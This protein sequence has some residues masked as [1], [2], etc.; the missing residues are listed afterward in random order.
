MLHLE[1]FFNLFNSE[2]MFGT[3]IT[4]LAV[5]AS[6]LAQSDATSS[7]PRSYVVTHTKDDYS[8]TRGGFVEETATNRR[9]LTFTTEVANYTSTKTLTHTPDAEI[10][11]AHV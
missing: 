8:Y 4:L 10:G 9:T 2:T 3:K 7:C 1:A 5:A 11:R 6:A